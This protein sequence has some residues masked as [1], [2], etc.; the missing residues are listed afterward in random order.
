MADSLRFRN[1]AVFV[2]DMQ[3]KF[4]PAIY[5]FAAITTTTK[6]LL[7][8]ASS[9]SIPIHSTTQTT[10]KLGPPIPELSSFLASPIDKSRFSMLPALAARLAPSSQVALVG[11]ESHVCITQTALDLRDAGHTPY[12]I[13]DAV[14]SCNAKEVDIALARLRAEP[15]VVVT[16]SESW[17]FECVGDADC[18]A[19]KHLFA[20]VKKSVADT[21]HVLAVL[22][23]K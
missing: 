3:E 20:L 21:K 11:I 18:P 15:G 2:C 19:F 4:R 9:L 1:P 23:P 5:E 7:A 8:F 10:S 17:M 12:V 6:K 13:A 22:P 14:S 16:S